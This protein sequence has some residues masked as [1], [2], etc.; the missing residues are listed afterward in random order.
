IDPAKTVKLLADLR[1]LVSSE[2]ISE[3]KLVSLAGKLNRYASLPVM[4]KLGRP[5]AAC[6]RKS[7][8]NITANFFIDVLSDPHAF[9][10][11]GPI[12]RSLDG[13]IALR[14]S[15]TACP[16]ESLSSGP[17]IWFH[18]EIDESILKPWALASKD[19]RVGTV[20]KDIKHSAPSAAKV[21]RSLKEIDE[22]ILKPWALTSKDRRVG[23]VAKDIVIAELLA[24]GGLSDYKV[25]IYTDNKAV[26]S[27]L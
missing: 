24:F 5:T 4:R 22:S 20:A 16:I 19:R 9:H 18:K 27:V 23:T 25:A 21:R 15:P 14:G 13:V 1:A 2:C 7:E 8:V 6:P 11:V 17:T 26:V 10:S 12:Q 3:Q